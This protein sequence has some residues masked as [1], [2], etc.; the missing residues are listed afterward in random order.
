MRLAL[1]LALM[2]NYNRADAIPELRLA[3]KLDSNLMALL[4]DYVEGH[5]ADLQNYRRLSIPC[6]VA[7]MP[8]DSNQPFLRREQRYTRFLER[9][10]LCGV[11]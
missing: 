10:V 3:V 1:G 9:V 8:G 11:L 4:P 6:K 5:Y 7:S 2:K